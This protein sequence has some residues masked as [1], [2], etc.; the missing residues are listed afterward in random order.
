LTSVLETLPHP[1]VS[2]ANAVRGALQDLYVAQVPVLAGLPPRSLGLLA[3]QGAL[4]AVE[5]GDQ[6]LRAGLLDRGL[7]IVVHGRMAAVLQSTV[8]VEMG[9]G[10][11]IGELA[12]FASAGQRTADVVALEPS[13]LLLLGRNSI[14]RLLRVDPEIAGRL[15]LNLA[16]VAIDRLNN[17]VDSLHDARDR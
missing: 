12:L 8:C 9:P 10:A 13:R 11:P 1:F 4:V 6:L 17:G 3:K 16:R 14:E 5:A 15:I 7:F 2:N